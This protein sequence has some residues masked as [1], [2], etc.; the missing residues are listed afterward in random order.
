MLK[1]KIPIWEQLHMRIIIT[2]AYTNTVH[3]IHKL[4]TNT[5]SL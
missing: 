2:F 3:H 1:E 4:L 5:F